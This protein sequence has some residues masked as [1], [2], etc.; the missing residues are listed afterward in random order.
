MNNIELRLVTN[1]NF[2]LI[3][4]LSDTLSDY[5]KRCVAPNVYSLAQAYLNQEIAWPRAIY[6][7][8]TPIGFIMLDLKPED[9][10]DDE[11]SY[12]LWRFMISSEYQGKGFGKKVLDL[13]IQKCMDDQ[14]SYLYT[15]CEMEGDMPY[16]FYLTYGFIDTGVME[17]GEEVL[18]FDLKL[19]K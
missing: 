4:K 16:Q 7:D 17:D 1:D 10:P 2:S 9:I 14:K 11:H 13:I 6:L 5:Q 15:S 18:K 19:K 8:E 3:T 12:Y